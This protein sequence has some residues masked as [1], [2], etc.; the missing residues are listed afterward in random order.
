MRLYHASGARSTRVVWMLEEIGLHYELVTMPSTRA[1]RDT[2][3]HRKRHVL[4]RVPVLEDEDG[5]LFESV[6]IL[7]QLADRHAEHMIGPLGS[8]Q[9]GLVYQWSLFS[10]TELEP[11]LGEAHNDRERGAARLAETCEALDAAV[12][13]SDFLV[14]DT[15][16]VAD[17]V[18]GGVLSSGRR[19]GIIEDALLKRLPALAA[20]ATRLEAR[21]AKQRAWAD[22]RRP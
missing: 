20:Y 21:P 10:M 5:M 4:G 13:G 3:E 2:P 9:R 12:D 1:E 6:A 18:C 19:L 11:A 16:T 14:C 7:L 22:G 17:I 15:L 8:R